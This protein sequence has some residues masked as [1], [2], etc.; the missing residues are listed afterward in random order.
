MNN[1]DEVLYIN[2]LLDIYK[3]LLTENQKRVME[4]YYVYNLSLS[5]IGEEL[6]ISRAAVNDTIKKSINSLKKYEN[7]LNLMQKRAKLQELCEKIEGN[8][9]IIL[10]IKEVL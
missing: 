5:E 7:S 9:D 2:S 1:L 6:S 4:M 3:N 8:E 10:E